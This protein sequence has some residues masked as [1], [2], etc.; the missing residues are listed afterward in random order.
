[1]L[2]VGM[3]KEGICTQLQGGAWAEVL[4]NHINVEEKHKLH[5]LPATTLLSAIVLEAA[6]GKRRTQQLLKKIEPLL[7]EINLDAKRRCMFI[8]RSGVRCRRYTAGGICMNHA[9]KTASYTDHFKSASIRDA[10]TKFKKDPRRL[11]LDPELA[12]LRLMMVQVVN[13][14]TNP[15]NGQMGMQ[16]I[17]AATV[18]AD[19]I[20]SMVESIS[21][22]SKLTPEYVDNVLNKVIE[23][24]AE[25]LPADKLE[26]AARKV[27]ALTLLEPEPDTPIDEGT[28]ISIEG[29]VHEVEVVDDT[30]H[31][32]RVLLNNYGHLISDEERKAFERELDPN[33]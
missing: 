6:L 10:F 13:L 25:Y 7:P 30:V 17:Q 8:E 24:M 33:S 26:E 1:M 2:Y 14:T 20:R 11:A 31:Q 9:I 32:K 27:Q 16:G 23:I 18:L 12:M 15:N 22:I 5:N 19:K 28:Q 4:A 21:A 3:S 29:E